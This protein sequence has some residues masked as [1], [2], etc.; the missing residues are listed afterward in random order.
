MLSAGSAILPFWPLGVTETQAL[1][2]VY[3]V[4]AR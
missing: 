3:A 4:T 2:V 1:L